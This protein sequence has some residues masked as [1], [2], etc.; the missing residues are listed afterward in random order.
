MTAELGLLW[1]R[2]EGVLSGL[3]HTELSHSRSLSDR[4]GLSMASLET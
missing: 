2:G 4:M 3:L 1:H